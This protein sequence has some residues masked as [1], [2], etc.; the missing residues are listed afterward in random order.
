MLFR[1]LAGLAL[2]VVPVKSAFD[3]F[4]NDIVVIIASA[5]VVSAAIAK[6]GIVE[7]ILRPLLPRL[8]TERRQVAALATATA[9]LSMMTKNVG[10]LA[11]LMPTALQLSKRTGTSPSR[12]LMP[13]SFGSLVGGLAIL[14]GTSPNIIVAGV[15]EEALGK[16][17]GMFDFMPVGQIGRAHV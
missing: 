8:T 3:G 11:I 5:L 6:S 2:G 15:R 10:A 16:P 12:L 4:S 13:M 17:F 1:S 14:V 9:L 7:L